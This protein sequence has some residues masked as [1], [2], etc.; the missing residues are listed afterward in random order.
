MHQN[1]R[2]AN[3]FWK[4]LKPQPQM[5][6]LPAPQKAAEEYNRSFDVLRN[7]L[8]ALHPPAERLSFTV[9]M[10]LQFTLRFVLCLL[11]CWGYSPSTIVMVSLVQFLIGP[12]SFFVNLTYTAAASGFYLAHYISCAL[13]SAFVFPHI[14]LPRLLIA[15]DGAFIAAFIAI[16]LLLSVFVHYAYGEPGRGHMKHFCYGFFM[17]RVIFSSSCPSWH[18]VSCP[19]HP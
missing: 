18:I 8:R 15:I 1:L 4:P 6:Q 17:Q 7:E 5:L 12:Y 14:P 19:P 16:D 2:N 13:L 11:A 10:I 3:E 9:I